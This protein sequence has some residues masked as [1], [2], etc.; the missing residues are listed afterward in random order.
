MLQRERQE[1]EAL[2]GLFENENSPS[3]Q[4]AHQTEYGSEDEE[5]NRDCLEVLWASESSRYTP[6]RSS[7]GLLESYVPMDM[8][9]D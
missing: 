2:L 8:S 6:S 4:E 9:T 5:F 7:V 1:I 3:E